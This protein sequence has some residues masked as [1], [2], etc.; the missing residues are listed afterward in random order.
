MTFE[1][2][3][4]WLKF[5]SGT[6]VHPSPHRNQLDWFVDPHGRVLADFI[7]NF[8]SDWELIA[9]KLKIRQPLP[10]KNKNPRREKHYTEYYTPKTRRLVAER[11][12]VD[13]EYFGFE[14]GSVS[15]VALMPNIRRGMEPH[16]SA[17]VGSETSLV[18]GSR[19]L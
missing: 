4:D 8:E 5:S 9:R 14:F 10:H 16:L 11:F 18:C 3:V 6:C 2:F 7:G 1:Q 17:T 13:I 15:S 19:D 12:K